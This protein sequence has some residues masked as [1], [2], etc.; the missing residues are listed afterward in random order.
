MKQQR[1]GVHPS[2][3][4]TGSDGSELE[5]KKIVLCITGSVAAYRAIDLA[6]LLMR[7][8]ADVHAV[9]S[10]AT[11]STLLHPEMMKW[12]TGNEVVSRLTGNLEHIALAD[13]GMS[14]LVVVYPC[15]ANT[16]GK[17][18]AGIDDT[19]VTSVLSVALGSKIP[20]IVAPA[21][22]EAMYE[23]RFIQQNVKK[24]QECGIMFVG[25]NMEEGKAKAAE[26]EQ[27][28]ASAIGAL[29]AK[30]PLAGKRVLVTAGSTVEYIDPIRVITNT[31]SG[32]M[33]VAIAREAEKMGAKVTLVYGHGTEEEPDDVARVVR[34]DTSAQMRGAVVAELLKKEE[35][36]D[37][38]IMAAAVSDYAPSSASAKKIDTRNGSRLDLS[39][40]ATKK[41]VD[42]VKKASK[43]TFLVAFK[44]DYGASD[45][46]LVDKAYKKLQEC[47]ADLVVANDIGRDGSKAGSDRNEVFIVDARK[48]VVHV[49]LDD[50][51]KIARKLL[52]L[53]SES[54]NGS[55]AGK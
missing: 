8:G 44:A 24:L 26:P 9:M 51:S 2:K 40:V 5:G 7:H 45:S 23:N 22:H 35:K 16:M 38:A 50:K 17:M 37:V 48:K 6:R 27:V 29:A 41:I 39:L 21:M 54:I 52:E 42:E 34:V 43:D 11:A 32:K 13:Y 49:P 19:P 20:V 12:A 10:E 36:C 46:T 14:D 4:I 15:T 3:D 33:G 30:G 28:L 47:G 1:R 18:A 55:K 31:S 25:P 53:V